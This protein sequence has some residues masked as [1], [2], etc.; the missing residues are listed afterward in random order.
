MFENDSKKYSYGLLGSKGTKFR[1]PRRYSILN[2]FVCLFFFQHRSKCFVLGA[3]SKVVPFF[4]ADLARGTSSSYSDRTRHTEH[5][6]I[7]R[8]TIQ[9]YKQ[10]FLRVREIIFIRVERVSWERTW[11]SREQTA[12]GKEIRTYYV[13]CLSLLFSC[14]YLLRSSDLLWCRQAA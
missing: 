3:R 11:W 12:A 6:A 10:C 7:S 5:A 14:T 8:P 2:G 13:L 4:R 1:S 9:S